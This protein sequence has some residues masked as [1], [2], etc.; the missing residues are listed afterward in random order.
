M[1]TDY[2]TVR[3]IEDRVA[4]LRRML[5]RSYTFD[6]TTVALA[7][8]DIATLRAIEPEYF[9]HPVP[10][11]HLRGK[12][13]EAH[14][15]TVSSKQATTTRKV[16]PE[17]VHE[18]AEDALR[19]AMPGYTDFDANLGGQ[20]RIAELE[21]DSDGVLFQVTTTDRLDPKQ[22]IIRLDVQLVDAEL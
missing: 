16:S 9:H 1:T 22:F 21:H 11:T 17:V 5:S 20:Y 18:W 13:A 2:Q 7:M 6:S 15:E 4:E 3:S 14:M 12:L 19:E 10:I 8:A